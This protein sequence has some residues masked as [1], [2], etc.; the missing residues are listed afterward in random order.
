MFTKKIIA[1]LN[2]TKK[3]LE[4][5][6][7]EKKGKNLVFLAAEMTPLDHIHFSQDVNQLYKAADFII[8]PLGAEDVLIK[9]LQEPKIKRH[10]RKI[11]KTLF[12]KKFHFVDEEGHIEYI[13]K[14]ELVCAMG[15]HKTSIKKTLASYEKIDYEPN[16]LTCYPLALSA[17]ATHVCGKDR[18]V[19][20]FLNE[21]LGHVITQE[22]GL[23]FSSHTFHFEKNFEKIS[24]QIQWF[25]NHLKNFSVD[26]IFVTGPL[27]FNQEL[28]NYLK[29][30]LLESVKR[31]SLKQNLLPFNLCH[32]FAVTI[33]SVFAL[34]QNHDFKKAVKVDQKLKKK[35]KASILKTCGQ[36][37]GGVMLVGFCFHI[38]F[39]KKEYALI[40][41]MRFAK[42]YYENE[43]LGKTSVP[44]KLETNYFKSPNV[45][46]EIEKLKKLKLKGNKALKHSP[47]TFCF[48]TLKEILY[49]FKKSNSQIETFHFDIK[50]NQLHLKVN[51]PVIHLEAIK[52][53]LPNA[54]IKVN[55][56]T[57]II[58]I[59]GK[60][61]A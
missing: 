13:R 24:K 27:S 14:N 54:D 8:A 46:F 25:L 34:N 31:P 51:T 16:F 48:P 53:Q 41:S 5:A 61:F 20:V 28:I 30:A 36:V 6:L 56:N 17:F 18:G 60:D 3:N 26:E 11:L 58:K 38:Y 22:H 4:I 59:K 37:I 21:N 19:F 23:P 1:A 32:S 55:N 39:L 45:A 12:K 33:G 44:K 2:I 42:T 10:Q 47:N 52:A 9:C 57:V 49:A 29:A 50:N 40:E 43:L 35:L 15:V 7:F